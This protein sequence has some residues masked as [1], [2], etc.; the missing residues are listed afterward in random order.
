MAPLV[1]AD[2]FIQIGTRLSTPNVYGLG[3]HQASLRLDINWKR[4][5]LWNRDESPDVCALCGRNILHAIFL[6]QKTPLDRSCY[7]VVGKIG[8]SFCIVSAILG[9]FDIHLHADEA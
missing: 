5:V 4:L 9:H 6:F 8:I 2:Q 7:R 3:E 1:F